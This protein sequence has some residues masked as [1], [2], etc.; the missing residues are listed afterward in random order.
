VLTKITILLIGWLLAACGAAA[1]TS[2]DATAPQGNAPEAVIASFNEAMNRQDFD[3]ALTHLADEVRFGATPMTHRPT[4]RNELTRY[5][6]YR[7]CALVIN[8]I[9][10]SGDGYSV[11]YHHAEREGAVCPDVG[12]ESTVMIGVEDGRITSLP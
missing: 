8:S 5:T 3:A 7:S 6:A 10:P 12:A 9:Q 1:P 4:I 2:P 11:T